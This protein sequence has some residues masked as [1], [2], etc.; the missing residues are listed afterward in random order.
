MG[1]ERADSARL[2]LAEWGCWWSGDAPLPPSPPLMVTNMRSTKLRSCDV[3]GCPA[4][5][6]AG[7]L[8]MAASIMVDRALRRT[9]LLNLY[10]TLRGEAR[11]MLSFSSPGAAVCRPR[12]RTARGKANT[13]AGRW[14]TERLAAR[15][16]P[17]VHHEARTSSRK[18]S[19][20]SGVTPPRFCCEPG[21][22][23]SF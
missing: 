7:K 21:S 8:A 10:W 3:G 4:H 17:P 13:G 2:G 11:T 6:V 5:S 1:P 12:R 16:T 15:A 14:A 19:M 18:G 23:L 9:R 22:F 20:F